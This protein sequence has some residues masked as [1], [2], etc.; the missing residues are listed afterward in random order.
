MNAYGAYGIT[1]VSG[2]FASVIIAFVAIMHFNQ[3]SDSGM[4]AIAAM[5]AAPAAMAVGV[6]ACITFGLVITADRRTP[7]RVARDV[8]SH[9]FTILRDDPYPQ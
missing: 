5:V 7:T 9:D 8:G 2:A 6:A 3:I 4:W 1:A